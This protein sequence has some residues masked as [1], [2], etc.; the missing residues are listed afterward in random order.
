VDRLPLAGI[1]TALDGTSPEPLVE[2]LRPAD[3][4]EL[5][6]SKLAQWSFFG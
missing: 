2:G 4:T 5:S 6:G 1:E 3:Q